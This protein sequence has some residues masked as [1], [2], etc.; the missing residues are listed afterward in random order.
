MY[1]KLLAVD[2]IDR[3]HPSSY[4]FYRRLNPRQTRGWGGACL[5]GAY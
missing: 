2:T 4:F 1:G 5:Y 3:V